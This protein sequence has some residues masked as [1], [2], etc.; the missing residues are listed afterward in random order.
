[1]NDKVTIIDYNEG[2]IKSIV[3][4]LGYLGE[5][6]RIVHTGVDLKNASKIIFPGQGHFA[7]AMNNLQ[8]Q[9]LVQAI[10][11]SISAKIPFLGICVGMQILFEESEEA[12]G[13]EGLSIIKG[14]V[15]K[16]RKGKTPQIG[17]NKITTTNNNSCLK[18]DFYYFVNSYYC[19]PADENVVAAKTIY[20]ESFCSAVETGGIIAVQFHPE[21]S[22]N[23]GCEF[24]RNW[25][26]KT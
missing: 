3:N 7:Q 2:N 6:C 1:M 25:L 5:D 26:N 17:W 13:V 21:K 23:A 11:D 10:K 12:P 19:D 24:F 9:D 4:M 22:S 15:K 16:F 14:K 20:H 8:K 18:D